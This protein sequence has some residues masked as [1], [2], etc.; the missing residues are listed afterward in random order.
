MTAAGKA[1]MRNAPDELAQARLLASQR[2]ESGEWLQ[3]PPMSA[4][5]LRMDDKYFGWQ[6]GSA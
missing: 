4:I 5:G 2:K 1:L 6:W 3:A